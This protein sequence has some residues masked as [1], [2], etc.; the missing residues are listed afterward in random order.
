MTMNVMEMLVISVV[1]MAPVMVIYHLVITPVSVILAT[2][3]LA[4][5]TNA[6]VTLCRT[7]LI[8]YCQLLV[9]Q[10]H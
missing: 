6:Q 10:L 3:P 5:I 7:E 1:F 4:M 8:N 2:T 9:N